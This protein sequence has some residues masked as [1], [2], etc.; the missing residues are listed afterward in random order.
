MQIQKENQTIIPFEEPAETSTTGSASFET[1]G[2][3]S[4]TASSTIFEELDEMVETAELAT[5]N[6]IDND[7]R[8]STLF[9]SSSF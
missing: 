4:E 6:A 3:E 1:E 2:F 9:A 5:A 7:S 8:E